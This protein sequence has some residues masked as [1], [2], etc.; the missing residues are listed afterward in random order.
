MGRFPRPSGDIGKELRSHR[1]SLSGTGKMYKSEA[2]SAGSTR[3]QRDVSYEIY[4][5]SVLGTRV[6]IPFEHGSKSMQTS[7][8]SKERKYRVKVE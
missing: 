5:V 2:D 7:P 6:S 3:L 1:C 8:H 4:E